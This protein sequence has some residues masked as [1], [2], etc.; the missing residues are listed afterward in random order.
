VLSRD[1]QLE[2]LVMAGGG[3][4]AIDGMPA[5]AAAVAAAT[6]PSVSS[7]G[8]LSCGGDTPLPVHNTSENRYNGRL[9]DGGD[10]VASTGAFSGSPPGA[11]PAEGL[12]KLALP[13]GSPALHSANTLPPPAHPRH[14]PPLPRRHTGD[15]ALGLSTFGFSAIDDAAHV[16]PPPGQGLFAR[17]LDSPPK[18]SGVAAFGRLHETVGSISADRTRS[19][20]VALRRQLAASSSVSVATA[21]T[22]LHSSAIARKANLDSAA[23]PPPAR[24]QPPVAPPIAPAIAALDTDLSARLLDKPDVDA[25]SVTDLV[26]KPVPAT[27]RGTNSGGTS[28]ELSL[29]APLASSLQAANNVKIKL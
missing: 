15:G 29:Q 12:A 13:S 8:D 19:D 4:T 22:A 17:L 14:P 24:T 28:A 25:T 16:V 5:P 23:P 20:D 18:T 9:S 27:R 6:L 1:A 21:A 26:L 3:A 10:S 7:G 11:A 2:A